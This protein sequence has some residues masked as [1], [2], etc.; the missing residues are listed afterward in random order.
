MLAALII[1]T[2]LALLLF[3]VSIIMACKKLEAESNPASVSPPV[4]QP[5]TITQVLQEQLKNVPVGCMWDVKKNVKTYRKVGNQYL[6]DGSAQTVY[7]S[8]TFITPDGPFK[9]FSIPLEENEWWFSNFR[10]ALK[11]NVQ[12]VTK[13]YGEL[14]AKERTKIKQID[15]EWDGVY[16]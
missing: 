6:F 10:A 12:I 4:F 11:N 1:F 13:E 7:V 2:V 3:V 16:N 15:D 14:V 5:G 8:I 9:S